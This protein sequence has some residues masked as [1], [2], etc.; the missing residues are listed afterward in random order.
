[1]S[2]ETDPDSAPKKPS[3]QSRLTILLIGGAALAG[4][5]LMC[6]IVFAIILQRS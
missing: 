5:V 6:A 3:F 1:M 4:I 2:E